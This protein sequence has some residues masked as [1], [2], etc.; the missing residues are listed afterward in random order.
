[1][2]NLPI[3]GGVMSQV[4]EFSSECAEPEVGEW[5]CRILDDLTAVEELMDWLEGRGFRDL[6]LNILENAKFEV[7]WR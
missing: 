7:L 3:R 1:M 2:G 6:E 5:Q 4:I